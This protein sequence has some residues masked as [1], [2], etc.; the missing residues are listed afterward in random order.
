MKKKNR[1]LTV[2]SLSAI[3]LFC[4]ALGVFMILCF[5]VFPYYRK[6]APPTPP[7]P[8][9]APPVPQVVIEKKV[10]ASLT[11]AISWKVRTA[12]GAAF[13]DLDDIDLHVDA[14]APNGTR[15][16]YYYPR[17][18][19]SFSDSPARLVTDSMRGGSE[20]WVHPAVTPG[21]Y[22]VSYVFFRKDGDRKDTELELLIISGEGKTKQITKI[23]PGNVKADSE[24]QVP[25][26]SIRVDENGH[27]DFTSL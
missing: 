24:K 13:S 23:I 7:Q 2:F 27:V 26:V 18:E 19:R 21:V 5:I 17:T 15:H 11:V 1:D 8:T 9:P 25:L 10:I 22:N 3:D 20:V 4:S 12:R 6:E 14:P 16:H